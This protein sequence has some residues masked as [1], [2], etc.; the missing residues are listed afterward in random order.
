LSQLNERC[1]ST[2]L[3]RR[4]SYETRDVRMVSQESRDR[5]PQG[6]GAVTVNDSN[7]AQA[8]QRRLIEKLINCVNRFIGPL[9]DNVQLRLALLLGSR[10][11]NFRSG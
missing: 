10:E 7:L 11:V 4:G 8:G 9:A 1:T 5:A 3:I 2:A 6:A